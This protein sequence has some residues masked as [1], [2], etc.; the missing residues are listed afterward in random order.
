MTTESK[1]TSELRE[2]NREIV[3]LKERIKRLENLLP[4]A[5]ERDNMRKVVKY[6]EMVEVALESDG[7]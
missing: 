4:T 7:L 3:V 2:L 1:P 5:L 6:A